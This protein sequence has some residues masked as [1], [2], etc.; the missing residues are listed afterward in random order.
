MLSRSQG[1]TDP[2]PGG[3][4]RPLLCLLPRRCLREAPSCREVSLQADEA[5]QLRLQGLQSD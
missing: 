4:R 5:S 2:G 3:R 1:D